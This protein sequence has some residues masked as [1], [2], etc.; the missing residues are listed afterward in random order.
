MDNDVSVGRI[1]HRIGTIPFKTLRPLVEAVCHKRAPGQAGEDEPRIGPSDVHWA[2]LPV[3]EGKMRRLGQRD[4]PTYHVDMLSSPRRIVYTALLGGYEGLLEQ[5]V[6]VESALDFVCLTD[7]PS[8]TSDTWTVVHIAP[9]YPHDLVRSARHAKLHPEFY[10]DDVSESLWIDNCVLLRKAPDDLL[11]EWLSGADLAVPIHSFRGKVLD[12]FAAV[13]INGL[14]DT[15]RVYEQMVHYQSEDPEGLEE[16]TLWTGIMAR[17]HTTQVNRTMTHW[18]EDILRYSRRDQLSMVHAARTTKTHIDKRIMDNN[19][20]EYHEWPHHVK[21]LPGSSRREWKAAM[22]SP[23]AENRI[24]EMQQ[25]SLRHQL[26]SIPE[27]V[28][29]FFTRVQ[30]RTDRRKSQRS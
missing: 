20:T 13:A 12:E 15:A 17:R 10:L 27:P 3:R 6:S 23:L 25:R 9:R 7:D 26:N 4:S 16:Q 21:R 8:M 28:R 24:A 18:F 14:D 22:M 5:P 2:S 1:R 11:A 19:S 29:D 30:E